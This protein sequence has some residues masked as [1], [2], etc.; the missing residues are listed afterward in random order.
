M[1]HTNARRKLYEYVVEALGMRITSGEYQPGDT[2]PNEESLCRE[3]EVSRG[4]L[5]EAA[6]VLCQKGLILSRPKIGTQ[7]LPRQDW[8][9]FDADVLIWKLQAGDKRDFMKNVIEVRRIVESEAAR[10]A[11]Q[12]A[13]KSELRAIR[14]HYQ[15]M[16]RALEQD[17]A[18]DYDEYLLLDMAFHRSILDAC[19]NDLLSQIGY[20]MRH[21]VQTARNLDTQDLNIQRASLPFHSRMLEAIA[22][23]AP[24]AAYKASQQMFDHIWQYLPTKK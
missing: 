14:D 7:V 8:N 22:R 2:L 13:D 12:R 15:E 21:A 10:Y 5:R 23:R 20:T 11:A 17:A 9:L 1:L 24:S 18:Y 3:F 19:H 4:V 16:S 6:K